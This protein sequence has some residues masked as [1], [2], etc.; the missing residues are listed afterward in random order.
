M[1][2]VS[3]SVL[4]FCASAALPK[5]N[6][7]HP[8]YFVPRGT[9]V[10]IMEAVSMLMWIKCRRMLTLDGQKRSCS[11]AVVDGHGKTWVAH[12]NV[13]FWKKAGVYNQQ[14]M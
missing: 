3:I 13:E 12:K 4:S 2:R 14:N 8:L 6:W 11:P 5:I 7:P 10:L 9:K 1:L